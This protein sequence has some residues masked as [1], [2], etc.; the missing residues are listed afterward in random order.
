MMTGAEID[1]WD[2]SVSSSYTVTLNDTLTVTSGNQELTIW[3]ENSTDI[4]TQQWI[5]N[6]E[7]MNSTFFYYWANTGGGNGPQGSLNCVNG[8]VYVVVSNTSIEFIGTSSI[9]INTTFQNL[10]QIQTQNDGGNFNSG[11]LNIGIQ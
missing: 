5:W 6:I 4:N 10:E 8:I 11:K 7:F 3:A 9:T 2:V 1:Y